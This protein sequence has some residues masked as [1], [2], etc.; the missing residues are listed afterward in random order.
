MLEAKLAA[1]DAA[2]ILLT[3][4]VAR[5]ALEVWQLFFFI[6]N[7]VCLFF[8]QLPSLCSLISFGVL[9]FFSFSFIF[10]FTS[11]S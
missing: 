6:I 11:T 9:H 4:G 7:F 2:G 8:L 3:C 1:A 10:D 5:L